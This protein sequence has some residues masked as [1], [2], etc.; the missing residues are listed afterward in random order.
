MVTKKE[1]EQNAQLF[2]LIISVAVFAL[3]S[4]FIIIHYRRI[5]SS[6]PISTQGQR[7]FDFGNLQPTLLVGGGL[8]I[9]F[10][11]GIAML[12]KTNIP[13]L[14]I[15]FYTLFYLWG[16]YQ[17]SKRIASVY[18][19]VVV[20]PKRGI[21]AFPKDVHNYGLSDYFSLKSIRELGDMEELDLPQIEKI[22]RQSG[23]ILFLHGA[24]GS[25]G[26]YFSRKQKRDECISAIQKN[27]K[28]G[29]LMIEL[30]SNS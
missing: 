12:G 17:Y 15:L 20:D 6:Y 28:P 21:V 26:I 14:L 10:P 24:F 9:A 30:E 8:I 4:V 19:G 16:M 3:F 18:F 22:T 27:I 2:G 25:R 11:L 1:R 29:A 5:K 13:G 7:V 23:K